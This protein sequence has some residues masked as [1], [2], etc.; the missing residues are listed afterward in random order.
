VVET[1]TAR[2]PYFDSEQL[3]RVFTQSGADTQPN[4]FP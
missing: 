1:K 3:I 2:S 4:T